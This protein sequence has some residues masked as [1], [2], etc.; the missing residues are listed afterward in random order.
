LDFDPYRP[1]SG[2]PFYDNF[3]EILLNMT[4]DSGINLNKIMIP[5]SDTEWIEMINIRA[6][7]IL[8]GMRGSPS[9]ADFESSPHNFSYINTGDSYS[10]KGYRALYQSNI[11]IMVYTIDA[12]ERHSQLWCLGIK[13]VKTNTPHKF[14]DLTKPLWYMNIWTY[15]IIWIIFIIAALSSATIIKFLLPKILE[16]RS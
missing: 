14:N 8:L 9:K 10:N 16:M 4:I 7:E 15:E 5:T 3:Y 6:P 13:W 2:H 1:E 11:S 12:K